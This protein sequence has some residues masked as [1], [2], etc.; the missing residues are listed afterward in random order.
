MSNFLNAGAYVRLCSRE[1]AKEKLLY[2][3]NQALSGFSAKLTDDQVKT[4]T[5]NFFYWLS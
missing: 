2:S 1:A 5:G 3:Y 4:L